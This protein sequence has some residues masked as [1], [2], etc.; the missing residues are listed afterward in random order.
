M[1]LELTEFTRPGKV[2][3]KQSVHSLS[4]ISY[5]DFQ[6]L[7][8]LY[9]ALKLLAPVDPLLF[10]F[11]I[12]LLQDLGYSKLPFSSFSFLPCCLLGVGEC[13]VLVLQ[14]FLHHI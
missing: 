7:G 8:P 11:G 3:F 6:A 9:C 12:L 1:E 10:Q 5:E 2:T 14:R 13:L 4:V